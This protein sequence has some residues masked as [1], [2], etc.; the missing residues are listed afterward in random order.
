MLW[1]E[2]QQEQ[3]LERPRNSAAPKG[4]QSQAKGQKSTE[5]VFVVLMIV[6]GTNIF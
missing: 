4:S 5:Y 2:L 6:S 3:L 1:V